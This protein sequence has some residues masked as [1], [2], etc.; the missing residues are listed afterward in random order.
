MLNM[1][2]MTVWEYLR[3]NVI[4]TVALAIILALI[5]ALS[6]VMIYLQLKAKKDASEHKEDSEEGTAEEAE[7]AKEEAQ[8]PKEE[9]EKPASEEPKETA[10]KASAPKQEAKKAEEKPVGFQD[11][12]WIIRKTEE[13]KFAFKLY[14]SNGAVMIDSNKEYAS[15]SGAKGGI[16]TYKKNLEENNCKIVSTK[17]GHFVY[18]LSNANGML[19]AVSSNYTSKSSCENAL[20][21]TRRYALNA[22]LEVLTDSHS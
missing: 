2:N 13:G 18:R 19:L 17:A 7:P 3:E 5:V 20:E 22:P 12:K 8:E 6:G 4:L 11:G 16:E 15:L 10:Q 9:A 21:A 14:A 1:L